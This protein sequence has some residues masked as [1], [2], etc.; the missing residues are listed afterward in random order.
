VQ[1]ANQKSCL[2]F[3]EPGTKLQLTDLF[4][5]SAVNLI[6]FSIRMLNH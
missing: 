5:L 1:F 3:I 2:H 6:Y 4:S